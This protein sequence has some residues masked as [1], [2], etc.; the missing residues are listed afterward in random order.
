MYDASYDRGLEFIIT[1]IFSVIKKIEPRAELHVYG[2]M[3]YIKDDN[4]K[5]KMIMLFSENGVTDVGSTC[6]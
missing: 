4:F 3:D 1:G 6:S 2:G 5:N